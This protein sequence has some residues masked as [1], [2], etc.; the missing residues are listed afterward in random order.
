MTETTLAATASQVVL[1]RVVGHQDTNL[2]GSVHGGVVMHLIDEAAAA[3]AARHAGV[4]ALTV[5][6]EGID[7]VSPA[8]AGDL[9]SARAQLF[10]VGRTSMRVH[11]VVTAERWNEL[12]PVLLVATGELVFVA[13][14]SEGTP[15]EVPR[16]TDANPDWLRETL[17]NSDAPAPFVPRETGQRPRQVRAD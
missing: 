8:R 12:G 16:L 6:V 2:Y 1:A 3:A 15:V 7:F 11:V 13:L 5:R 17:T 4:P 10:A 9:L 14:D